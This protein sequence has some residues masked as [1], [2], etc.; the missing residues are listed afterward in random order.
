MPIHLFPCE[1]VYW[2]NLENHKDIKDK[3]LPIVLK[4]NQKIKN[5]PFYGCKFNTG[6]YGN[7][8]QTR[9]KNGFLYEEDI[10][11]SLVYNNLFEMIQEYNKLNMIQF[12]KENFLVHG[13]WWNV[14][15]E[16]EFQ[17]RHAHHGEPVYT[18]GETYYPCFSLIYILKDEN[19]KSSLVF[20]KSP[21]LP[22]LPP[23]VGYE[24]F[25]ENTPSIKEGTV[26]IFPY[27]LMHMVK[28]CIKPG[29]VTIAYNILAAWNN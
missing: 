22:L 28:P 24:F 19:E 3:L 20:N 17:E 6:F 11:K 9:S 10:L 25:T 16:G 4:E 15:E 26:L 27:N 12:N 7:Y 29:R 21:P 23:F 2:Q 1:Y 14:Y 13:A 18:E 8:E 5:N